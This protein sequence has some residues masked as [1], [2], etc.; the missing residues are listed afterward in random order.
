MTDEELKALVASLA[1]AQK[2]TDEQMN[3]TDQQMKRTG[4][5]L[6]RTGEQLKRTEELI[7]L[8]AISQKETKEQMK[9]ADEQFKRTDEQFKRTDEQFKRTDEQ[10]KRTD[11]QL[12]RTDEQLKRT[13]EQ[14]KRTDEQ[15]KRT[16]EKLERIGI[17]VGNIGQNQGDVAEEFFLHSL[18]KDNRL[19]S[20]RFDDVVKNM[21]KHRGRIHEEY[22]LV[23][24]NGNAIGIVE[25][26]Y[27]AHIKDLD[28]LDRKMKHFK[29]LFPIYESF[30]QYGA[31]AAFHINEDA[32]QEALDR[33]YFVL[34]RSGDLVH[35]ESAENLA[36]L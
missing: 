1:E 17:T 30:R 13:D 34:Q 29:P 15:L 28:K 6:K 32:K 14:L 27:K 4:E 24:T 2:K 31:I 22:D 35:T 11:E 21:E 7:R 33:G 26:K 20:I 10:F 19:G 16:D 5:Q 8:N 36:V 3:H 9:R 12:K 23:M 18:M 25:V